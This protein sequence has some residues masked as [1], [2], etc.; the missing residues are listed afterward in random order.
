M[1]ENF[2]SF[3]Q[4]IDTVADDTDNTGVKM[5]YGEY[6]LNQSP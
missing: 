5:Y 2:E 1:S 4:L 6:S 3:P